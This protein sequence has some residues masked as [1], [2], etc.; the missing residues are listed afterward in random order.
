MRRFKGAIP[1]VLGKRRTSDIEKEKITSISCFRNWDL[2]VEVEDNPKSTPAYV[3]AAPV[4]V[5]FQSDDEPEEVS[6]AVEL[7]KERKNGQ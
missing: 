3:G 4:V 1:D 7:G 5:S 6:N 2:P